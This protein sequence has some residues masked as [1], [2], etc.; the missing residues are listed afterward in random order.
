MMINNKGIVLFF[1][2]LLSSS[3]FA[4]LVVNKSIIIYYDPLIS[5]E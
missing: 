1:G 5:Q 3:S 4:E 2:L